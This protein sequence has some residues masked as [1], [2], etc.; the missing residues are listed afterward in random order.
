MHHIDPIQL[1]VDRLINHYEK[2]ILLEFEA[3]WC[4]SCK[5][6]EPVINELAE[7]FSQQLRLVKINVDE[8]PEL[9]A[10]FGIRSIPTFQFIKDKQPVARFIGPTAK[11][12]LSS[13]IHNLL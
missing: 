2:P 12:E 3:P 7:E 4:G 9:S 6:M 5:A 8:N 1:E 13:T 11:G 10:R